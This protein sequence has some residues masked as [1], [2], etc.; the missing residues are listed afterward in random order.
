MNTGPLESPGPNILGP[1][2]PPPIS[3]APSEV[4]ITV[5]HILSECRIYDKE[6]RQFQILDHFTEMLKLDL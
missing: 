6:R 1:F 2:N 3:R 5:K 4:P